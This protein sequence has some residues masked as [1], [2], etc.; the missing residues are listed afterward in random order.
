M[1]TIV[2]IDEELCS[3]CGACADLCPKGIL[4]V[5]EAQNVCKV[6]DE[7]ECDKLRGCERVCPTGAI[8]IKG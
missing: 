8:S 5:D 3:G 6:T 2:V 4:F 7:T 1:N